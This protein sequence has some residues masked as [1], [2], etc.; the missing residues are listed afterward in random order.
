MDDQQKQL[1]MKS[2]SKKRSRRVR[3]RGDEGL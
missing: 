3:G 2:T 1:G